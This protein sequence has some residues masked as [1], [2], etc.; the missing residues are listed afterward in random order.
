MPSLEAA[1]GPHPRAADP[2]SRH[3]ARSHPQRIRNPAA[4]L[5]ISSTSSKT[6]EQVARAVGPFVYQAVSDDS[7]PRVDFTYASSAFTFV[8]SRSSCDN[9]L[10]RSALGVPVFAC[11]VT[12]TSEF[13]AVIIPKS[14]R[15]ALNSPQVDYWREA[16]AKELGGLLQLGTW[17]LV[18]ATSMP[19]GANLMHCHYVFTVKR[20]ADGSIE[21]FKARLVA[22]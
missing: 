12:L 8:P 16:I 22:D 21:K 13:G 7:F 15:Q 20:K 19:S 4:S 1:P 17:K 9:W 14:Y 18:P 5:H 3:F 6:Y 2:S 10:V 11:A